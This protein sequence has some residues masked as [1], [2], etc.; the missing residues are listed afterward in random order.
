VPTVDD[1]G[2]DYVSAALRRENGAFHG[3]DDEV[4]AIAAT[5]PRGAVAVAGLS[6]AVLLAIWVAFFLFV[7]LPRGA[8]G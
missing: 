7:Y 2:E 3:T 1:R 5:G 6:V 4:L 8:I